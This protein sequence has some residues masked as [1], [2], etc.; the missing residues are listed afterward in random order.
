MKNK[1]V[2]KFFICIQ[3]DVMQIARVNLYNIWECHLMKTY[4][5]MTTWIR[6]AHHLWKTL[7]FLITSKT[8][9][10]YEYQNSYIMPSFILG[11][12][13]M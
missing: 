5:G 8:L 12:K 3:A 6:F 2:S 11:Y 9:F 7:G 10:P 13:S 4:I 1:P